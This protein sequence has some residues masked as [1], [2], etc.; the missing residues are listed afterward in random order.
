LAVEEFQRAVALD[1]H[2]ALARAA[3]AS[4]YAQQFFYDASDQGLDQKAFVEIEQALALDPDLAEAWLARAQLQWTAAQRFPH[5]AAI[6][7]LLRAIAINPNFADAYLELEKIYYHIGLTDRAVDA[8]EQANRLDPFRPE[9]S[10]RAFRA[11][12]DAGRLE[13]VRLEMERN[14]QL[15]SYARAEALVL[16]GRLEEA[17]QL[18]SSSRIILSTDPD[19]DLGGFALL[20]LVHARLGN[21]QEALRIVAKAI[22]GAEN[23][24]GL[25]HMHHAQFNIGA[26]LAWLG[27]PDDALRWLTRAAEE[28]YP[29]Y[30]KFSSDPSLAPVK[31]HARFEALIER[32][33]K[34]WDR[35]QETLLEP[36]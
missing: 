1:S 24:S 6:S 21:R 28:G 17:R 32:L 2:F 26:A 11:L 29:S 35:W 23:R 19:F 7:D 27:K 18:L 3:L 10:N 16:M 22:P 34:Q 9:T 4:A 14:Q 25:S 31:G 8:H 33:R 30:P 12:I 15:G 5:E 36:Q 13:P 20:G